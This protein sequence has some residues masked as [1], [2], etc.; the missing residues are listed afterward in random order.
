MIIV[1]TLQWRHNEN[2]GVSN[3]QPH[4][5]LLNHLLRRWSNKTSKLRTTGLCAGNSSVVGEF[6]VQGASSMEFFSIS[7][8]HHDLI[9]NSFLSSSHR[10]S[11]STQTR[12]GGYDLSEV[13]YGVTHLYSIVSCGGNL[14]IDYH[15]SIHSRL[16]AS[17]KSNMYHHQKC[18]DPRLIWYG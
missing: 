10:L 4:G 2:D 14:L 15:L 12:H 9:W 18:D 11:S 16:H 17:D 3:H 13:R 1:N 7:W 5:C 6:P 8:R